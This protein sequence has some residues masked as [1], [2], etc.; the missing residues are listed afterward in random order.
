MIRLLTCHLYNQNGG[1]GEGGRFAGKCALAR[2]CLA[3]RARRRAMRNDTAATRANATAAA[4]PARLK[5]HRHV[6]SPR[7]D[8]CSRTYFR[9]YRSASNV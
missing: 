1:G 3:S 8:I 2:H 9:Q 5:R 4:S 6:V 7:E